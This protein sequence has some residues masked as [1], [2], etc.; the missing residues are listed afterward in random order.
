MVPDAEKGDV[1]IESEDIVLSSE[2]SFSR[3]ELG[4]SCVLA[5]KPAVGSVRKRKPRILP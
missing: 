2:K 3:I 4:K 5:R 1:L